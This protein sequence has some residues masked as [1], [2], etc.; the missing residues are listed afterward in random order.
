M[1][2]LLIKLKDGTVL[3]GIFALHAIMADELSIKF[4][5]IIDVGFVTR[6]RKIWCNRKPH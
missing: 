4:E 5:D 1:P 3:E 2:T 6:D